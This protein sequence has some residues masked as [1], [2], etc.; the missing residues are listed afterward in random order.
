MGMKA[1]DYIVRIN[2]QPWKRVSVVGLLITF[3]F[4]GY[5]AFWTLRGNGWVPLVDDAN[6][7]VHEAGHPLVG[8][9]SNR[10]AVYGG[11]LMQLALPAV[12]VFEFWRRRDTLSCALCGIWLGQSL[13]N[14][15][16]YMADARAMQLPLAGFGESVLHDWNVILTRWGLLQQDV[17][18]ANGLRIV[19]WVGIAASLW[20][21]A[22]RRQAGKREATPRQ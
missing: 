15:A 19:A 2:A 18:L 3:V 17:I 11:T 6:F 20:F 21:L 22:Y 7:G 14:V 10:L 12:C 1:L 5:I 13:L 16:R 4:A 8:M 9:F